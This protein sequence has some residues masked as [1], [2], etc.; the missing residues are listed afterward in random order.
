MKR[1]NDNGTVIEHRSGSLESMTVA[2]LREALAQCLNRI[3]DNIVEAVRLVDILVNVHGEDLSDIRNGWMAQI[4]KVVA[5][6][7]LPDVLQRFGTSVLTSAISRLPHVDQQRLAEGERVLFVEEDAHGNKTHRKISPDELLP[8][9]VKQVFA[10]DH[11]R[12]EREQELWLANEREKG[13]RKGP[14]KVGSMKID[15]ELQGITHKGE[16]ISKADLLA[17]IRA[18]G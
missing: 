15:R 17:A 7:L 6:K 16:F 18:L 10:A 12:N 2:E 14:N 5:K 8:E 1:N 13:R 11:I 9:Q 4:R 3:K